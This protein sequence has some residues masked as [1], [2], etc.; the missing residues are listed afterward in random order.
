MRLLVTG[1][2]G[3]L[4]LNLALEVSREHEVYGSVNRNLLKDAPF[5]VIQT[6][7]TQPGSIDDL[8]EKSQPD[9][10]INCAALANLRGA[11]S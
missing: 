8:L 11:A 6:D 10:V 7:L 5:T 1:A 4:G 2:S 3:L 9:W